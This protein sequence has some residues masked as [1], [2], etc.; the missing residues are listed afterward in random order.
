MKNGELNTILIE[1]FPE[2]KVKY[3]EELEYNDYEEASSHNLYESIFVPYI[4]NCIEDNVDVEIKKSFSFI[5]SVL[6]TEDSY[7][8]EVIIFSVIEPILSEYCQNKK[9]LVNKILTSSGPKT[10]LIF[11]SFF[12]RYKMHEEYY[13]TD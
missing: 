10:K 3:L 12:K 1:C 13:S 4:K 5:E 7:A 8:E 2:L 11:E 9:E 6:N